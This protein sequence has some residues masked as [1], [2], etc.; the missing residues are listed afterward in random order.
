[1][2]YKGDKGM[3]DEAELFNE[4]E[5]E[6]ETCSD[7]GELLEDCECDQDEEEICSD[8]EHP[9]SECECVF[10]EEEANDETVL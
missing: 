5:G 6:N 7:C 9:L 2:E 1:M 3:N 4:T 10:D 8:C